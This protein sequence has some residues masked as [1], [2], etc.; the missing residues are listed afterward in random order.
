MSIELARGQKVALVGPNG[1]G[2]STLIRCILGL[3]RCEGSVSIDGKSP[4]SNRVELARRLAYVPQVAPALSAS[5]REM[6]GLVCTTRSLTRQ[7]VSL[8]ASSIDLDLDAI[9]DRPFRQLSGGMKQKT[10]L[11]LALASQPDLL[12]MDEPSAS[13]DA[14]G[15]LRFLSLLKNLRSEVTL[16]LCSHRLD[17]FSSSKNGEQTLAQ[18]VIELKEGRVSFDGPV[19]AYVESVEAHLRTAQAT[20]APE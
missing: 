6:V 9:L 8:S 5:V 16:I 1:S 19:R 14:F 3:V 17:E 11:A 15:R 13:L 12:V 20:G 2:K 4:Y 10:L 18:Q 7:A